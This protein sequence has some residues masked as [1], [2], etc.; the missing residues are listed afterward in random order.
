MGF[1]NIKFNRIRSAMLQLLHAD[2]QTDRLQYSLHRYATA[3]KVSLLTSQRAHFD[4]FSVV[5]RPNS[6]L[7]RLIVEVSR[8]HTPRHTHT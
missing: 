8:S 5:Q 6:G 4:F 2:R 1:S 7:G 3:T